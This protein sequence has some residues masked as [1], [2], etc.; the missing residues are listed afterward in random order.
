MMLPRLHAHN[1]QSV[2]S[3]HALYRLASETVPGSGFKTLVLCYHSVSDDWAHALAVTPR[4]FERQLVSLL[5]R[6]FRPVTADDLL[7]GRR[8]GLYVTFDDAYKDVLDAV[9]ILE[10]LGL[11]ATVFA[12]TA[13]AEA[14]RPLAVPELADQAAAFPERL[15]TMSW[16]EL[17]GL[18]ARGFEI[19]SHTVSH[20]H[21]P[22][23]SD[24]ELDRELAESRARIE[25]ELGRPC[26][27]LAYPYGE[28][29][30]RVQAAARRAGYAAAFALWAGSSPEN[31]YA[32]PRID[33]YRRDSLL[34]AT[35]K[36]SFLKPHAT[37]L[38]SRLRARSAA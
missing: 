8:R 6:G 26:P 5:R 24:A 13:F 11:S 9:P 17:R 25:D 4:A 34:R 2:L 14:G 7:T 20:A 30:A 19:G 12:A 22:E 15:A 35:L 21:L 28:H 3:L 23:L 10:R 37:A 1:P 38:L 31:V 32:L 33:F 18:A 27:L 36:S 29:D 16:D